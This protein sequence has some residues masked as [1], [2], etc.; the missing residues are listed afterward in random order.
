[1]CFVRITPSSLLVVMPESSQRRTSIFAKK[2]DEFSK[3]KLA[4]SLDY[5]FGRGTSRS[6]DFS[7]LEFQ[8]S[9]RT[10]RIKYVGMKDSKELLFT[11]RPNGSIAPTLRAYR[12]L[13]SKSKLKKIRLRPK[14]TVTVI[15]GVSDIV[16]NGRTVFCKHVASCNDSLRAGQD[17]VV[18]NE[19][20]E[21]LATGRSVLSGPTIKQFKRGVA[22]K[23]REGSRKNATDES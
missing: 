11:F 12:I 14:W 15:D 9:N 7:N 4:M 16:S 8:H 20:G 23:V 1:M 5:I 21:L 13:L 22:V 6:L 3:S 18:L 17:V 2:R 10:G 19:N